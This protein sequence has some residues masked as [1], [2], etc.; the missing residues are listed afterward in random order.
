VADETGILGYALTKMYGSI[1]EVGPLICVPDRVDV[2]LKLLKSALGKLADFDVYL[3]I[4]KNQMALQA[5]LNSVGF[6]EEFYLTR[7][8][9]S[10]KLSKNCIYVAESKERG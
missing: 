10:P 6:R 4:Q 7:M 9:L 3:C 5:Y 8:F 2:A 1:A